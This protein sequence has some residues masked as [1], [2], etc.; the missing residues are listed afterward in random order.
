MDKPKE[1]IYIGRKKDKKPRHISL[2][3]YRYKL[4]VILGI[5][6]CLLAGYYYLISENRLTKII[7]IETIIIDIR[8]E[9]E[10]LRQEI[11]LLN[12]DK[13]ILLE[14]NN[15]LSKTNNSLN[16]HN[17]F[18]ENQ[19]EELIQDVKTITEEI[20]NTRE[21]VNNIAEELE[22][23]ICQDDN[24]DYVELQDNSYNHNKL[25]EVVVNLLYVHNSVSKI[26]NNIVEIETY[27]ESTQKTPSII[28]TFG[29][30]TSYFGNRITPYSNYYQ[31]HTGVDIANSMNTQI[32]AAAKGKVIYAGR[33]GTYG[34]LIIIDHDNG[35]QTYYAHLNSI[36]VNIEDEINQ[37]DIIGYMGQTGR[38]TGVH[39]HYEVR[40]NGKPL[41]PIQYFK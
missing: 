15:L 10:F 34:R 2:Y 30:I 3:K 5:I 1:N 26:N 6:I 37:G 7:E 41:N 9:N 13:D 32:Q 28:P 36:V 25:E 19:I 20:E 23:E 16:I 33:R 38:T 35:Y 4:F 22:Y 18:L 17:N 31:F 29:N 12:H 24:K 11:E 21:I 39:L 14:S 27:I 40:Y 8:N